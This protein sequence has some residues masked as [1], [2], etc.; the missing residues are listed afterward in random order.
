MANSACTS[1]T[2]ELFLQKAKAKYV[3]HV[4]HF[5]TQNIKKMCTRE[6]IF[7]AINNFSLLHGGHSQVKLAFFFSSLHVLEGEEYSGHCCH[8]VPRP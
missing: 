6:L 4:S 3:M 2:P 1:V 8:V 7:N 5:A